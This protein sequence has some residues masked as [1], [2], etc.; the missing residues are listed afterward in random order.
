MGLMAS[1]SGGG[2]YE[3]V[4]EGR[5]RAVC[6]KIVDGG[7]L[8]EG[9]QSEPER[10]RHCVFLFWEL[11]DLRMDDDRP[12]SIFKQYTLSLNENSALHKHLKAWRNKSFSEKEMNGGFDL[13]TVLGVSCEIEVDHNS[14]GRAV[15]TSIFPPTG[16]A[17]KTATVNDQVAFDIDIYCAEFAGNSSPESKA[18]C[19][20][21]DEL[22]RFMCERIETSLEMQAALRKGNK[23]APA[24]LA[25]M[26][27]K[28][29]D[30][31]EGNGGAADFDDEIPF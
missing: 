31:D 13:R 6:Y 3:Q 22:P 4:P 19:D 7:T 10:P 29:D 5:H 17:R 18:H 9:F 14:N 27:Q 21:F 11:P 24:G 12:M 25:A 1:S 30:D 2:G 16:G 8:M 15:V 23:A 28:K 26:A 20:M